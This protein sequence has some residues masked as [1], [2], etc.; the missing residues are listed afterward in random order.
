MA[1]PFFG[2]KPTATFDRP[3]Y[4]KKDL[5]NTSLRNNVVIK[6]KKFSLCPKI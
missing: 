1:I 6:K 3:W 4:K 2:Q 5:K